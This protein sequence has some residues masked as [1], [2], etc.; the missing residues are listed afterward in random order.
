MY[1]F[2]FHL[3]NGIPVVP[4]LGE[5]GDS[6]MIKVLKYIVSIHN[7]EDL[8]VPNNKIFQLKKIYKSNIESFIKH[9]NFD[10][11]S[12]LEDELDDTSDSNGY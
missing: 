10:D 3:E 6:E 1:S 11:I 9:Y 4:F 7:K 12:E 5:K 2:A 8:R